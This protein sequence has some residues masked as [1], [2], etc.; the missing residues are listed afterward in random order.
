[1]S[2]VDPEF[3]IERKV[4]DR[5]ELEFFDRSISPEPLI[6]IARAKDA[7]GRNIELKRGDVYLCFLNPLA[8]DYLQICEAHGARRGAWIGEAHRT[9]IASRHDV[10]ALVR[11]YGE[12]MAAT[13]HSKAD[14]A[15]R[16]AGEAARR[17]DDREWNRR[18]LNPAPLTPAEHAAAASAKDAADLAELAL[19]RM[20]ATAP[21]TNPGQTTFDPFSGE[22]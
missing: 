17:N 21:E 22:E 4:S 13:A 3:A 14:V 7:Q 5:L 8:P 20:D 9:I 16:A 19:S 1:V 18:L 15:R 10:D 2:I 12:V 6:Y 11:N